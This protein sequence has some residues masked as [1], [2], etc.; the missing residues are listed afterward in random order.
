[1]ILRWLLAAMAALGFF[2]PFSV[3]FGQNPAS[4]D[5]SAQD[6][7]ELRGAGATFP[8]PL[9]QKWIAVYTQ[10]HPHVAIRYQE[11]GSGEGS[12]LFLEQQVDFGASDAALSD[13]QIARAKAGVTL[14][15]ATAGII[16]LAYNLPDVQGPPLKLSREVYADMF[17]GKIRQWNDP[18][19]QALNPE[20][21]LPKQT[22]TLVTRQDSSGTTFAL[23]NHLSAISDTW[24]NQGPGVGKLIDWPGVSMSARG[25]EGVA[26]RIKRSWGSIGYVEYGFAKRLQLPLVHLQN[27]AGR[28]VEPSSQSGQAALAANV[29]QIPSNLRVFLPDPDG[30]EAYPI[31]TFTWLLLQDRYEDGQK[32]AVLKDFVHWALTDG[33]SYSDGLGYIP[34]PTDVVML[35]RTAVDAIIQ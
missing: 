14:V 34:L 33:Q 9:Y 1:M 7:V 13:E 22:I 3:A 35:A 31:V 26:A 16:V 8:A 24:R 10:T 6:R 18:R 20:L 19:I 29:S 27:K 11:V 23:T 12:K 25:N 17:T 15:P 5:A 30:E 32:G 21:K 28:F 4:A 2:S